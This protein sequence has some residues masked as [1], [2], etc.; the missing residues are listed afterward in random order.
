[1]SDDST[2]LAQF[3]ASEVAVA[4]FENPVWEQAQS[5]AITRYW[6]GDP[7]PEARHGYAN[8]IWSNQ[9]LTIRYRCNQREPLLVNHDPD[10]SKKKIGLWER[11]VCE[12]FIAPGPAIPSCYFEFEVAPTGEW[13]DLAIDFT[14]GQRET[15]WIFNS[16]MKAAAKVLEDEVLMAMQIPWSASLP[17]PVISDLWRINLFRCVGLGK[18]RY[19][20]WQPTRTPEPLFHVPQ[21]FGYLKFVS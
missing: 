20:A 2:L 19:L 5:A 10:L 12:L 8:I 15:D 4:D 11:D 13:I 17:K 6:S 1:M 7:A 9:A 3:T 14:S 18:D 16:G 21:A